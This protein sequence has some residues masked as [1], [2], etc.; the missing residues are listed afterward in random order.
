MVGAVVID[1]RLGL[2]VEVRCLDLAD[3]DR[4]GA[5]LQS[6]DQSA[7]ETGGAP[8]STGAPVPAAHPFA[9]AELSCEQ[10]GVAPAEL[11][12]QLPLQGTRTLM[13]NA[14]LRRIR[15]VRVGVAIDADEQ[16]RWFHSERAH[17]GC[18]QARAQIAQA[19]R[20]D[21]HAGRE[22]AHPRDEVEGG[23]GTGGGLHGGQ[24]RSAS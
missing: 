22:A 5:G 16:P 4:V 10:S 3:E 20:D 23:T 2:L 18:G 8:D 1:Q 21:G 24:P 17:R 6:L 7:L 13:A 9:Q 11:N 15:C 12:R 14:R 19:G